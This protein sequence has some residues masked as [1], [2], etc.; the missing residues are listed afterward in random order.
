MLLSFVLERLGT[1]IKISHT[2]TPRV[3]HET[4]STINQ[5][6]IAMYAKSLFRPVSRW[7]SHGIQLVYLR[8][9]NQGS[10]IRGRPLRVDGIRSVR[11][12][13]LEQTPQAIDLHT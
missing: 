10:S 2:A 9:I 5:F 7:R 1:S 3:L 13:D 12:D 8:I 6:V 11:G 4:I